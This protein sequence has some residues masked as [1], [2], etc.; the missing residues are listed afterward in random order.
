MCELIKRGQ[1]E[2]TWYCNFVCSN[3]ERKKEKNL[4]VGLMLYT[5]NTHRLLVVSTECSPSNCQLPSCYCPGTA[6]P[7]NM[8]VSSV[9]QMVML[10]FDDEVSAAFY[11]YYQRLFR[12]GRYNPNGC[13]VR[14]C[15]FVSGS[16]TTYDLVYPLYALGVEIASHSVS[17]RFPHTWWSGASYKDF[18]DEAKGMRDNLINQAGVPRSAIKGFRVPF[19][20][21]GSDN[22]YSALYDSGFE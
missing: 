20:Q 19:L 5:Q 8:P 21:L 14:G 11:G 22:M 18:V 9:P 13:P 3:Q 15:L 1:V 10:T 4:W 17:H 7:N 16:G 2:T 6:I 12:P